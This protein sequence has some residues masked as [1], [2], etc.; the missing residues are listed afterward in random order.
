MHAFKSIFLINLSFD[1]LFAFFLYIWI[2]TWLL[3]RFKQNVEINVLQNSKLNVLCPNPGSVLQDQ[4]SG[5]PQEL[6]YENM[7]IVTK[8]DYDM[9]KVN[10]SAGRRILSCDSPLKLKYYQMVFRAYSPPRLD[11][12][13][14]IRLEFAP[15]TKYYFIGR[16]LSRLSMA[17]V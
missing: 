17:F 9:C 7:W 1:W 11:E 3:Y 5:I 15:G 12:S 10:I 16:A 14:D 6:M 4:E 8:E 13:V 2:R